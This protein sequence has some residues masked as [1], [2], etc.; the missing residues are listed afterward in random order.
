MTASAVSSL[1]IEG[2][3]YGKDWAAPSI[4]RPGGRHDTFRT[5]APAKQVRSATA[6]GFDGAAQRSSP[7]PP[8]G[9]WG[10]QVG[11]GGLGHDVAAQ[12][13]FPEAPRVRQGLGARGR[14]RPIA[15]AR[16]SIERATSTIR[17]W[18]MPKG[19][20]RGSKSPGC[21]CIRV[22]STVRGIRAPDARPGSTACAAQASACW[23]ARV[24]ACAA[25]AARVRA[26]EES[27]PAC[28]SV[29]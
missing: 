18:P 19:R 16:R 6:T 13:S 14:W 17:R 28:I 7:G 24:R 21:S 4:M 15:R 5:A 3:S 22:A 12:E 27:A 23:A 2:S 20:T 1:V 11:E 25:A 10:L 8:P 26:S 9:P 29:R